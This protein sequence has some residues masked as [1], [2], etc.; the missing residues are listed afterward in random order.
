MFGKYIL[1]CWC[2]SVAHCSSCSIIIGTSLCGLSLFGSVPFL[3]VYDA[4][5]NVWFRLTPGS[6]FS[7]SSTLE[8]EEESGRYARC[9]QHFE[10]HCLR[11]MP[12]AAKSGRFRGTSSPRQIR[13]R[14][15][16][17]TSFRFVPP[18]LH[19]T[20]EQVLYTR[21]PFLHGHHHLWRCLQQVPAPTARTSES[22]SSIKLR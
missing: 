3:V 12:A 20:F 10:E 2:R 18:L 8:S 17:S 21:Y 6:P 14:Q 16:A 4:V 11:K 19:C 13:A 9:I 22:E 15:R 1:Y 7:W 5:K